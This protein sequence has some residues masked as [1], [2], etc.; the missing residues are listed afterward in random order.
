MHATQTRLI[1]AP[2][3][4]LHCFRNIHIGFLG[5]LGVKN[6]KLESK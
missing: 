3:A 6:N 2:A 1:S 4:K 5:K